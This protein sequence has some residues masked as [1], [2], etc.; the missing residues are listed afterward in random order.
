MTFNTAPPLAAAFFA[1]TTTLLRFFG[2]A[3]FFLVTDLVSLA[4]WV[5]GYLELIPVF[6]VAC[7][8]SSIYFNVDDAALYAL[9]VLA[10]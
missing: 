4:R 6:G 1:L 5:E 3:S 2:S 9:L 7:F 10:L 8:F